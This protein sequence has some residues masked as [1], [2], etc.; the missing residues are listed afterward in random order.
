MGVTATFA[1]KKN[2]KKDCALA[3]EPEVVYQMMMRILIIHHN[4]GGS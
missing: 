1:E 3:P 2:K 4:A